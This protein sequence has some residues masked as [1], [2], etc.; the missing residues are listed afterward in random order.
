M[1][2]IENAEGYPY[3]KLARKEGVDYEDV[4]NLA[5]GIEAESS[6]NLPRVWAELAWKSLI[7]K[8]GEVE[9][10]RIHTRIV[11]LVHDTMEMFRRGLY[12]NV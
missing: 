4:L 3:M 12:A 7:Q 2:D 8:V 11:I 5:D 6:G 10:V 9:A 1:K